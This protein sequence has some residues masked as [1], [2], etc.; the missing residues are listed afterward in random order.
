MKVCNKCRNQKE[1]TE[2]SKDKNRKDG[3]SYTCKLCVSML[4]QKTLNTRLTKYKENKDICESKI[5]AACHIQK[6]S[7]EF[8]KDIHTK[9]GV[10]SR[11]KSCTRTKNSSNAKRKECLSKY[12]R[13]HKKHY[14]ELKKQRYK[15]DINFRLRCILGSRLSEAVRRKFKKGK[16]IDL[17]GC[18][19]DEFIKYIETKFIDKMSWNNYGKTGWELDH[20]K[21]LCSFDLS[22]KEEQEKAMNFTNYQPLWVK[23]N[24]CK[25]GKV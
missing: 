14:A 22:L 21:P 8:Y 16:T 18:S 5:C 2:F 10:S 24:Q 19:V 12:R 15:K 11:C 6:F 3:R 1:L 4:V 9:C 7:T 17:L 25:G 23:D 13:A 20:I